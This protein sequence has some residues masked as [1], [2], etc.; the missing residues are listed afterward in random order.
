MNFANWTNTHRAPHLAQK[1]DLYH[2]HL[3]RIDDS[4]QISRTD[5]Q[6]T[7]YF[8]M[9]YASLTL[10]PENRFQSYSM[11]IMLFS[12]IQWKIFN[13]LSRSAYYRPNPYPSL[14]AIFFTL[15]LG[16]TSCPSQGNKQVYHKF[17]HLSSLHGQH[18]HSLLILVKYLVRHFQT[19]FRILQS[20]SPQ[21]CKPP[22]DKIANTLYS[23]Q[24]DYIELTKARCL[25]E[26]LYLP[27]TTQICEDLQQPRKRPWAAV[28]H[29]SKNQSSNQTLV[30]LQFCIA[31]FM[32]RYNSPSST[33]RE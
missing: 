29:T 13:I 9:D 11:L 18:I 2:P 23:C 32:R 1:I 27:L 21:F 33:A 19:T 16:Q 30:A 28:S 22:L 25:V 24:F 14:L 8:E 31:T 10:H 15:K 17:K 26:T 6:E 20:K 4:D 7:L 5:V 12:R 3:G